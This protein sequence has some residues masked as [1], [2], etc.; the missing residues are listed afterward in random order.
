MFSTH[1]DNSIPIISYFDIISLFAA[2]FEETKI[3]VSGIGLMLALAC[4]S[5]CF[6]FCSHLFSKAFFTSVIASFLTIEMTQKAFV[7]ECQSS[8]RL[9]YDL[10]FMT[11]L[12]AIEKGQV[13]IT[14]QNKYFFGGCILE[15]ACLSMWQ[16]VHLR[17]RLCTEKKK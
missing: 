9:P 17:V 16:S 6:N 14:L 7:D 11:V 2:E 12:M 5:L 1:S 8:Q 4:N 10:Y 3:G 15:S 13:T